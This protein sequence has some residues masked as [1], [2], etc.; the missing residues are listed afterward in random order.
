[1]GNKNN[2]L[3]REAGEGYYGVRKRSFRPMLIVGALPCAPTP[4]SRHAG[5]GLGVRA[6]KH[7]T[8]LFRRVG[9]GLGVRAKKHTTPLS[10]RVGEGLGVRAKTRDTPLP[11]RGRGAG[12]RA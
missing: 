11:P 4:L 8:P 12:V 2:P 1:M 10:R 9:E 7:T 5:E 3:S 6:K